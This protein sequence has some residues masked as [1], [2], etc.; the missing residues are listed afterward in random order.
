MPAW[1]WVLEALGCFPHLAGFYKCLCRNAFIEEKS[2]MLLRN[3]HV[4]TR[5]RENSTN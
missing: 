3:A 1:N 2:S 4:Y 5:K